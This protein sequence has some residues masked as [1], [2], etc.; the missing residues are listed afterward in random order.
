MATIGVIA[1]DGVGPEVVREALAVLAAAAA[2]DD[3]H[4]TLV[5]FDLGGERY[6]KT[7][8]VLPGRATAGSTGA[9]GPVPAPGPVVPSASMPCAA[10]IAAISSLTR[11]VSWSI[12]AVRA[13]IWSSRMRAS[14]PWCGSNRPFQ[15]LGQLRALGPHPAAGQ[16]RQRLRVPLPGDQRLEHRPDRLGVYAGGDRGDL[17]QRAFEQLFQPRPVPGPLV[18]QVGAQPGELPQPPDAHTAAR[19]TGGACPARPAWP[20]TPRPSRRFWPGLARSS[21]P[22]R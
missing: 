4:Y 18:H 14:S 9:S 20:A 1:G 2:R 17:D 22:G 7:G 10:G 11:A 15:R 12:W 16:V 21:P 5:P 19:T 3:F 8:E 6:L 13:S